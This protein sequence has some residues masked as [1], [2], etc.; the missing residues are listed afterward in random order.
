MALEVSVIASAERLQAQRDQRVEA[1]RTRQR[2]EA[3]QRAREAE[4]QAEE[5]R[6][7]E[8]SSDNID[9]ARLERE[10]QRDIADANLIEDLIAE[11]VIDRRIEDRL[12]QEE[13]DL[14]RFF[15]DQQT[16]DAFLNAADDQLPAL[17]PTAPQP[18]PEIQDVAAS[19]SAGPDRFQQLLEDRN[20]RLTERAQA[21]R[22]F[23]ETQDREFTRSLRSVEELQTN[24][25]AFPGEPPRGSVVDFSA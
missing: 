15:A 12:V 7:A 20:T 3:V 11:D 14:N 13:A 23:I 16:R 4:R 21:D 6:R 18:A 24:P 10:F 5:R 22:Q 9:R 8:R 19:Q 25:A 1:A 2:E 17:T